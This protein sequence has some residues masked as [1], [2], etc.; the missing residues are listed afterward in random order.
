M[1]GWGGGGSERGVAMGIGV[2]VGSVKWEM[3]CGVCTVC[4]FGCSF[5]AFRLNVGKLTWGRVGAS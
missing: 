4:L 3:S 5:E 2:V 1:H